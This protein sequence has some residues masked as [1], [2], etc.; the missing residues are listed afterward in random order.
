MSDSPSSLWRMVHNQVADVPDADATMW[1]G[2]LQSEGDIYVVSVQAPKEKMT[3]RNL[4]NALRAALATHILD[5]GGDLQ[6]A[7]KDAQLL[8]QE[9]IDPSAI[10]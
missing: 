9:Q 1:Q 10:N 4:V 7:F 8:E 6:N 2:A 5:G 3:K